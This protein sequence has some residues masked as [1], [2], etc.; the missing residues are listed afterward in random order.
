M[1]G[2]PHDRPMRRRGSMKRIVAAAA[3]TVLAPLPVFAGTEHATSAQIVSHTGSGLDASPASV[4]GSVTPFRYLRLPG[5]AFHPVSNG[6][7]FSY[8]GSGCINRA[9]A[10]TA[11]FTHK[12]VLPQGSTVKYMRVYYN[13]TSADDL[14]AFF[15]S[16]DME[17]NFNEHTSVGSSGNAGFGSDLSPE[18]T[19][20]VDH[21]V[22]PFVVTVNMDGSVDSTLQFCGVRIAYIDVAD[23]TIFKN[24]FD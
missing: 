5:S 11:L 8:S 3:L 16:Y 10:T 9:G 24:G 20:V 6:V 14:S 23:D 18:I 15:T 4:T 2:Y 21:F 1:N 13:D 7:T 22:E 17:G 19:K 12:V